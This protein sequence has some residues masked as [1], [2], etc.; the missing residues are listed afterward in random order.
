MRENK[1]YSIQIEIFKKAMVVILIIYKV[2]FKTRTN[3]NQR[4][5]LPT[6]KWINLT[7]KYKNCKN[8]YTH[9]LEEGMATR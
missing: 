4:R 9:S 1:K 7:R 2:D 3:K 5:T 6:D 8:I